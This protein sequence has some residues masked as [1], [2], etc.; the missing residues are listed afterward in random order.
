VIDFIKR[1][2]KRTSI[3]VTHFIAWLGITPSKYYDWQSRYGKA[4]EHNASPFS[5]AL[6]AVYTSCS[7]ASNSVFERPVLDA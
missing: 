6:R 3:A 5:S 2:A 1:W 7:S 4:N